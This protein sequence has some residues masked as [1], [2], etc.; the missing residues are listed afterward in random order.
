MLEGILDEGGKD[1][2]WHHYFC[3]HF[4]GHVDMYINLVAVTQFHQ[5]NVHA[6]KFYFML[7]GC[8]TVVSFVKCI[9]HHSRQFHNRPFGSLLVNIDK[10]MYVVERVHEE[11]RIDLKAQLCQLLFQCLLFER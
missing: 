10:S 3:R 1:H 7:Q 4:L 2:G 8:Q 9:S 11:M 6:Q 5:R